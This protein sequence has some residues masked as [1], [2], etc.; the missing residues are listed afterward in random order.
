MRPP[1]AIEPW[2]V[3]T[4]LEQLGQLIVRFQPDGMAINPEYYRYWLLDGRDPE[5]R[6]RSDPPL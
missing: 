4:A 1:G 2:G 3:T 5:K 6:P